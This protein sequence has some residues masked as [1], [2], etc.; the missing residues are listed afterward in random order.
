MVAVWDNANAYMSTLYGIGDAHALA[1]ETHMI[2]NVPP[3]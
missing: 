2:A 3:T 1:R